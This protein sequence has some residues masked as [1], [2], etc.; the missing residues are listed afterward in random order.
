MNINWEM[1]KYPMVYGGVKQTYPNVAPGQP[2]FSRAVKVGNLIFLGQMAGRTMASTWQKMEIPENVE[3]QVKISFDK[4]KAIV[5]EAGGSLDNLIR[6]ELWL[7]DYKDYPLIRKAELEYYQK[8][9]PVLIEEPPVYS[10][11][12]LVSMAHQLYKEEIGAIAVVNRDEPGWEMK[13]YPMHYGG[14][15]Q[16]YPN[17][18]AGMTMSSRSVA[19]G[20]LLF[21]S[22][23]DSRSLETGEVTSNEVEDQ[24]VVVLDKIRFAVEEAGSSMDNVVWTAISVRDFEDYPRIQKAILKYYGKHAPLL[25]EEPPITGVIQPVSLAEPD[26]L[27]EIEAIAVVD[28]N[29]HGW[30]MKKYTMYDDGTKQ[31]ATRSVVIGNMILCS[32]VDPRSPKTGE[33]TSNDFEQQMI[34]CLDKIRYALEEA[35]GSMNHMFKLSMII[36]DMKDYTLMRKTELEYYLKHAPLLVEEPPG[37]GPI[38]PRALTRPDYLIQLGQARG[39]IVK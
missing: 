15:Q 33:L 9:A 23:M 4:L 38:Q 17:I 37:S 35:G 3:E 12:N 11:L 1:T 7:R 31:V 25:V 19:V 32:G 39:M 20:N 28:R 10:A 34:V 8:H 13:K 14:V 18:P 6:T 5:E 36:K 29:R 24:T 16:T 26:H 27:V 21:I 2:I 22:S 30:E